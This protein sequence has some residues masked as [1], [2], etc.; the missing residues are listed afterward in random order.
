VIK[1]ESNQ[2]LKL[3]IVSS[4]NNTNHAE[5]PFFPKVPPGLDTKSIKSGKQTTRAPLCNRNVTN[6]TAYSEFAFRGAKYT[7]H[8]PVHDKMLSRSGLN[9]I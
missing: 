1:P 2:V 8:C 5:K 7:K 4:K 6:V 9:S 3:A